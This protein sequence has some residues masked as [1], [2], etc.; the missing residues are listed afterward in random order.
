MSEDCVFCKIRNGD[1]PSDILYQDEHCFVIRDI[2]PIAPTHLLI[3]PTRHFEYLMEMEPDFYA[4]L[5]AMFSAA[6]DSAQVEGISESGYRLVVNQRDDAGQMVPHLHM[7]VIGGRRLE[8][9]G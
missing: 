9:L 8:G 2:A 1:I 3:I 7:H 5:G 4:T 6:R